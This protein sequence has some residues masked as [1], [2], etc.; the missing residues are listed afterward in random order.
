[1]L[2]AIAACAGG[3]RAAGRTSRPTGSRV[4]PPRD[5]AH[6]DAATNAA[7]VLAKPAGRPPLA[8]AEALAA[9]LLELPEVESVE[10]AKP[11]FVN[12]RLDRRFLAR[13]RSAIAL[14]A[15][16]RYGAADLGQRPHGQRRVLLGQ[17][18]RAAARRPRPRHG[19]RRRARQPAGAGWAGAV[20][21]E[22]Y[23]NDG[24][25]QI[26]ARRALGPPPL[27]RG[28][29]RGAGRAA[30]GL[31]SRRLSDPARPRRSPSRT[32]RAGATRPRASGCRCSARARS[33]RCWR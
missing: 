31:L 16:A 25:A 30:R 29:R 4:E 3:G 5:P 33:T 10:I 1:M 13:A 8:I 26:D 2:A 9:R 12:L 19:V 32:A 7:L 27:P 20:M 14:R 18:E 17:P 15:G 28:A 6:G 24:G 11:G 22:Y 23:V 21:R